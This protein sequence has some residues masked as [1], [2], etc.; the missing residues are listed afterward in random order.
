[1]ITR[2]SIAS[3]FLLSAVACTP[4]SGVEA[5]KPLM[6][7]RGPLARV[8][9]SYSGGLF[10]RQVETSFRMD[11]DGYAMVGHLGGDG[12]IQVLY[13]ESSRLGGWT[14]GKKTIRLDRFHARDDGAPTAYRMASAPFR[15]MGSQMDSYDGLGHGFIFLITS[16]QPIDFSV[17]EDMDGFIDLE[18]A[19]YDYTPDPRR[20]VVTLASVIAPSGYR[21][22]Y[23]TSFTT[24]P[25][26][27][28]SSRVFDCG[29]LAS[30]YGRSPFGY[31]FMSGFPFWSSWGM[32]ML[33][34]HFSAGDRPLWHSVR[35]SPCYDRYAYVDRSRF[36]FNQVTV[37]TTSPG[38]IT[39]T[40]SRL[41]PRM[42]DPT[43]A[44]TAGNRSAFDRSTGRAS[45]D[46]SSRA[47]ARRPT[48]GPAGERVTIQ[49][50][51][52]N[53]RSRSFDDRPRRASYDPPRETRVEHGTGSVSTGSSRP[54]PTRES[55]PPPTTTT[56][57]TKAER[58]PKPN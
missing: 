31:S 25:Y 13:P 14:K 27:S 30:M 51:D 5:P 41:R 56:T 10:L 6:S 19:D 29:V 38:P 52:R 40:L 49:S 26:A 28:Y 37:P 58:P 46:G 23:A 33:G 35:G 34:W 57:P 20:A 3:L 50:I 9:A 1:M 21:I 32:P 18:V 44:T 45:G 11:E 16:K 12:H 47:R 36:R 55:A 8:Y 43:Q 15:N 24:M 4:R 17:V 39:R 7:E 48:D 22:K 54:T 53:G 42:T 2:K